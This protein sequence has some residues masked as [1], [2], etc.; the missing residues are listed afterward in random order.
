MNKIDM[1]AKDKLSGLYGNTTA[2]FMI[3]QEIIPVCALRGVNMEKVISTDFP[4]SC[5][6]GRSFMMRI[7]IT[8]QPQ[9]QIV[10]E[11]IREKALRCAGRGDSTRNC[12]CNRPDERAAGRKRD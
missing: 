6:T 12:G 9:R 7:T 2:K 3:L 11:M 1:V 5:R 8:D 4:I 10:A